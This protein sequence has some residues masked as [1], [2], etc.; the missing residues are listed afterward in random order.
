MARR[1]A[2]IL[3]IGPERE[4]IKARGWKK[5]TAEEIER[6]R[7]AELKAFSTRDLSPQKIFITK[8][9]QLKILEVGLAK[10]TATWKARPEEQTWEHI[11]TSVQGVVL[12]T[13]GYM[14]PEQV[15][16]RPSDCGSDIFSCG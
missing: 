8:T 13:L 2:P 11:P 6:T 14:S 7:Q 15:C 3:E 10:L 9:A 12:G 1:P 4:R 5:K 16:G